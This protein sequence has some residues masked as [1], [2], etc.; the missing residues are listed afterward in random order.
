MPE[1]RNDRIAIIDA[2][3]SAD[4]DNPLVRAVIGDIQHMDRRAREQIAF[5]GEIPDFI[6]IPPVGDE[7]ERVALAIWTGQFTHAISWQVQNEIQ[8][9]LES[10]VALACLPQE[11]RTVWLS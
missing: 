7:A 4:I 5:V 10:R 1:Q 9:A 2:L 11:P 8:H 3:Q 6:Y